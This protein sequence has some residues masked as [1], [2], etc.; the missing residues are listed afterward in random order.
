MLAESAGAD[1]GVS[2]DF[3]GLELE[4]GFWANANPA[5]AMTAAAMAALV[6]L[7]INWISW[8]WLT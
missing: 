4:P 5:V 6:A 1:F 8:E 2:T 7:I 3:A